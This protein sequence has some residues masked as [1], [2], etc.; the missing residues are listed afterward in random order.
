MRSLLAVIVALILVRPVAAMPP[1][2]KK[3]ESLYAG[4]GASP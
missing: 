3:F 1:F 4:A 2:L